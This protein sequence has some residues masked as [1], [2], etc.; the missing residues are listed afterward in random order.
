MVSHLSLQ[1]SPSLNAAVGFSLVG[2]GFLVFL[3]GLP[4]NRVDFLEMVD[5]F[6]EFALFAHQHSVA[7]LQFPKAQAQR[8]LLCAPARGMGRAMAPLLLKLFNRCVKDLAVFEQ[9]KR[10]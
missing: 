2:M 4:K 5:A 3:H 10:L 9:I 8:V 1:A 7:S 6:T